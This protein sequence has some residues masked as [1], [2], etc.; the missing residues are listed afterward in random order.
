MNY[1]N[2]FTNYLTISTNNY[3]YRDIGGIS[4]LKIIF[5]N[6]TDYVIDAA[7]VI[8]GYVQANG[9]YYKTEIVNFENIEAFSQQTQYAPN[10]DRGLRVEIDYEQIYSK[11]MHFLYPSNNGNPEDPYF[12]K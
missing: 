1:R 7:S 2:N 10:S 3:S 12:Y 8:V 9:N 6:N 5:N 11:K 4:D